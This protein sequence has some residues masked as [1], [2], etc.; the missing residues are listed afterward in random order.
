MWRGNSML[1]VSFAQS[2]SRRNRIWWDGLGNVIQGTPILI[3]TGDDQ[4]DIFF[5]QAQPYL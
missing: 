5:Q 3:L 1:A 2:R 4:T